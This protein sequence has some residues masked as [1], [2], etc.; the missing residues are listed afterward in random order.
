MDFKANMK[1]YIAEAIGTAVLTLVGCGTAVVTGSVIATAIAF[2]LSVV[3]MAYCLGRISGCHINPAISLG[4]FIDG[5]MKKEDFIMYIVFQFIGG[6]VGAGLL[7]LILTQFGGADGNIKDFVKMM[8]LGTNGFGEDYNAAALT[9]FGAIIVEILLTFVFVLAALGVTS[10][11]ATAAQ[12]GIVIGLALTLV[13]LMGIS[14]TGTSVNP[15]RSFGPA[16]FMAFVGE[17]LAIKQVWVFIVAPLIGA[18][19]AALVWKVLKP[20]ADSE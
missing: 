5:R 1:A 14:L 6:I 16:M 19:L 12:G 3:A 18:A 20:A 9:A 2:G 10:T 13:H 7:F 17:S 15:A 4:M 11:K 8:G